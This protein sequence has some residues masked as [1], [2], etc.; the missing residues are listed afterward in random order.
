M[1]AAG[2]G[3]FE[4]LR[5]RA[6]ALI[7]SRG[8]QVPPPTSDEIRQLAHDL[9]VHQVELEIQN[10]ELQATQ[11]RVAV[12]LSQYAQ[13]YHRA[14]VGFLTLDENGIIL[15]CNQTFRE[16]L[17]EPQFETVGGSLAKLLEPPEREVL[18]ARYR[19][20]FHAPEGKTLE[21]RLVRK[22]M[23]P[24]HVRL[25]G[26][27]EADLSSTGARP[28]RR[29]LLAVS[30]ISE[31]AK[32]AEALRDSEMLLRTTLEAAPIILFTLDRDGV[33]TL[34]TGAGLQRLGLSPDQMVGRSHADLFSGLDAVNENIRRALGG[35]AVSFVYEA[36]GVVW[37]VHCT[38]HFGSDRQ[39]QGMIGTAIDISERRRA[40]S[41]MRALESQVQHL[42]RLEGIGRLAGGI[43]HDMNNV[44]A[45]IMAVASLLNQKEGS[46]SRQAGLILEAAKRGRDLVQGLMSFARKEVETADQV[47]LN[48]LVRQEADLLASTTL[49]KIRIELDLAPDLPLLVGSETALSTSLM[50]LC[51]NALDAMPEGGTL[52][53]RTAQSADQALE[54]S[55]EDTGQG[56]SPEV[57]S[58]AIEP[59]FT[60]KPVGK[61]TGLGLSIVYGTVKAHGG[62]IRLCSD[63]GRGTQVHIR[64]PMAPGLQLTAV[65]AAAPI[66]PAPSPDLRILLV[67]DDPLM[68]E[69]V[70]VMLESLG[71]RVVVAEGGRQALG[72]LREGGAFDIALLDLNMPDL[73][74]METL[75]QLR[76]L[77]PGLPVLITTGFADDLTRTRLAAYPRVDL[78][79]KPY[80]V[81]EIQAKLAS[82]N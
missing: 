49:K 40:E 35:E 74:G 71:H 51:V 68:R 14:P 26:R 22:G 58:R 10:E 46:V 80:T 77:A 32:A 52:T 43:A 34:S 69:T 23:A 36:K 63:P 3:S 8:G 45:S 11:Q 15:Q 53:L 78:L 25:A 42:H 27:L 82:R 56:M 12:A 75:V 47:D 41:E 24:L 70:P 73:D 16:M 76:Q 59:F 66:A 62:T 30:N 81:E 55:V 48:R 57:A 9:S 37:D 1:S 7:S 17:G 65:P 19:A 6:E 67:D 13:L 61:G 64:L 50:N 5:K 39:L 79:T 38:P 21:A 29:L 33:F 4:A 44:L 2:R 18:L 28:A 20:I 54:L 31:E 60:T 72:L